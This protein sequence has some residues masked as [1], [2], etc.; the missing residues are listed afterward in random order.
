[1]A[2]AGQRGIASAIA[3]KRIPAPKTARLAAAERVVIAVERK[4]DLPLL[5]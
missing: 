1:M 3:V 2:A 5:M 4:G